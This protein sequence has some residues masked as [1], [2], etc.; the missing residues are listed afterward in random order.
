MPVRLFPSHAFGGEGRWENDG[1]VTAVFRILEMVMMLQ[2]SRPPKCWA[3]GGEDRQGQDS[4]GWRTG[5][6]VPS[7][8]TA[9]LLRGVPR[10]WFTRN[11]HPFRKVY[12]HVVVGGDTLTEGLL[13]F[14]S[15]SQ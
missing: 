1:E 2:L 4:V 14:E 3:T 8:L 5:H 12:L 11:G 7:P 6:L 15:G 13:T 9:S 10:I